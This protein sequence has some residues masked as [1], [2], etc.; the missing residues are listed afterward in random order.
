MQIKLYLRANQHALQ[1][2]LQFNSITPVTKN[3]HTKQFRPGIPAEIPEIFYPSFFLD[4]AKCI[5]AHSRA[6]PGEL[7]NGISRAW[8]IAHAEL[9]AA[10]SLI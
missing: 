10:L 3:M 1:F 8:N 9:R 6:S 4:S 7:F 5:I 2:H